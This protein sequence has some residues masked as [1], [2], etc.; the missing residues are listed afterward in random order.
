MSTKTREERIE[1]L[2]NRTKRGAQERD[3]KGLGR[4][5]VLDLSKANGPVH[6]FAIELEKGKTG[7]IDLLPFEITQPWYKDLRMKSGTLTGLDI[8]DWDYKLEIPV[9]SNVGD[10]NDKYLCLQQAFGQRCFAC[11]QLYAEWDKP[12]AEQNEKKIKSLYASWRCFYNV[13]DYNSEA[14]LIELGFDISYKLFEEM[15]QE[16]TDSDPDGLTTFWDLLDGRS[17]EFKT[18][19]K[20]LGKNTFHEAHSINFLARDPYEEAIMKKTH[21][22]DA[23]LIIPTYEQV[24]MAY[25]G[26]DPDKE[27]EEE[28]EEGEEEQQGSG[29]QRRRRIGGG[30]PSELKS[31]SVKEEEKELEDDIPFKCPYGGVF[32]KDCNNLP[33]CEKCEET[34][35][36][37]CAKAYDDKAPVDK[38]KESIP[39]SPP[40]QP[41]RRRIT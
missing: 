20:R 28:E 10:N 24:K 16:A 32:G 31:D 1:K 8:G 40:E 33:E 15:L 36:N 11:E 25:L 39:E 23:M 34:I 35:Y 19:E 13:Y 38:P 3:Q 14:G 2:K 21:S 9:H 30:S 37:A 12:E 29:V 18:R 17:I 7:L 5:S 6:K 26:I 4:K 27:G 22:L 41:R